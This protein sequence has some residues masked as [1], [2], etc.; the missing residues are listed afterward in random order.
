MR[1]ARA[2]Q[3]QPRAAHP[4]HA[5]PTSGGLHVQVI[6]KCWQPL[7]R[8]RAQLILVTFGGASVKKA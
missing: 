6:A 2:A 1:G 3:G 8:I 7:G 5:R 4:Q